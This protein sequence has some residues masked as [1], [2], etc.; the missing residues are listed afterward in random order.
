VP[1]ILPQDGTLRCTYST[2]HIG[3]LHREAYR[4]AYTPTQGIQ[5]GI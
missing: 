4:E 2:V 1:P 3:R 5:G